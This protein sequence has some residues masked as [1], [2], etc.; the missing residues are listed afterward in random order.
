[1][2]GDKKDT[3]ISEAELQI[4]FTELRAEFSAIVSPCGSRVTCDPAPT[5]TDADYLV[6]IPVGQRIALDLVAK[7]CGAGWHW[8]GSEHYQKAVSDG[9][10]SWKRGHVNLI[11]TSN[12]HFWERHQLAT[13]VCKKLNLM[14]KPDRIVLFQALL[15]DKGP[16][17]PMPG[18]YRNLHNDLVE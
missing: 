10:M 5:D 13:A 3:P 14:H 12:R 18:G 9:F 7:L 16:E 6:L 8:D 4:V 1:M 17:E 2:N 11:I 15:Y